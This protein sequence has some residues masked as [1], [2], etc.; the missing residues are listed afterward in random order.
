MAAY[1]FW[2]TILRLEFVGLLRQ[3]DFWP[4]IIF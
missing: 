2:W 1:S 3:H 4:P